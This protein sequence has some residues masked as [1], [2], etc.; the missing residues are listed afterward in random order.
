[1]EPFCEVRTP[2][3]NY[4]P[5]RLA[6]G[7]VVTPLARRLAGEAGI[8]LA[9]VKGSGPHGR[10]VARDVEQVRQAP[11][12]APAAAAANIVL[13][14]EVALGQALA[15]C[16]DV[17]AIELADIIVKAWAAALVRATPAA[18]SDI[19]LRL[20]DSRAVI[21]D[22]AGKS[23]TAIAGARR[24]AATANETPGT[25]NAISMPNVPGIASIADV[26]R[27]PHTT[28]LSLGA[29]RRAPV[30]A[31]DGSVTFIDA[32]TATLTCDARTVDAELGAG[33]LAAFQG[34]VERP[35]TLIV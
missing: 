13:T 35:V 6:G 23:L 11:A 22:A 33:L 2:A 1:M 7:T 24:D 20:G 21:R 3:R 5:A 26:L 18:P 28:V 8:D 10:I 34:F 9:A 17:P 19:A 32:V 25:A 12:A 4:G 15:L 27:P 30:E 29:A 31:P 16:A 14:A